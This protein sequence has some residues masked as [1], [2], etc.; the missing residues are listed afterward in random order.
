M[1]RS[2]GFAKLAFWKQCYLSSALLYGCGLL[3]YTYV[4]FFQLISSHLSSA[5]AAFI[6]YLL[7]APIYYLTNRSTI[8]PSHPLVL[9]R[10]VAR[11]LEQLKVCKF[12]APSDTEKLSLQFL[13]VKL[14]FL[15]MMLKFCW[16]NL[17]AFLYMPGF[18]F[19]YQAIIYLIFFVDT[20]V[21]LFA[22]V[23]ELRSLGNIVRS[24][25]PTLLGWGVALVCYPPLNV[26]I[27]IPMPRDYNRDYGG[28]MITTF[29]HCAIIL[30]LLIYVAATIALGAKASN[31][32]NRG[33]VSKF[34]YSIVR[35]PAYIAKVCS[36]WL[37]L[38]PVVSWPMF[39]GMS[40]WTI[41]YVLR[42]ITEERHL[43]RDPEYI[44]YC[45]KVRWRFI[46]G[47]C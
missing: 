33:I 5:I 28:E 22:Y 14:I 16:E 19:Q 18:I 7:C 3:I 34:P 29:F 39:L 43:L 13:T 35:H 47:I 36:W 10:F 38:I 8:R 20:A 26:W 12:C 21:F 32:T 24:V 17:D 44:A 42:A 9:V 2:T 15:P 45:R 27:T 25:E 31:L 41:I 23:F 40:W 6:V 46:P 37:C 4:P 11:N 1:V 30:F